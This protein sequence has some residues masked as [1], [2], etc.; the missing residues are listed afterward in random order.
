MKSLI[1]RFFKDR[2]VSL[3]VYCVA[4]IGFLEMYVAIYPSISSQAARFNELFASYPQEFL[5]AFGIDRLDMSTLENYIAMEHFSMIWPLMLVI[6][7]ISIAGGALAGEIDRG[8]IELLLARPISRLKLFI[9]R[10]LYGFIALVIFILATVFTVIPLAEMH[11]VTYDADRYL[12]ISILGLFF[13]L[14][15]FSLSMLV[16]ALFSE[17]GR[18]SMIMGGSLVL[19]YVLNVVAS[20]KENLSDLKY[21]SFFHYFDAQSALTKGE[22][23]WTSIW[24]FAGI[25]IVS[26]II[27]AMVWKRRDV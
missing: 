2:R 6:F 5:K 12:I 3:L 18:V 4:G 9:G 20:L 23:N 8:T 15:V 17:R 25:I 27:G 26:T 1:T 11:K 22:L 7:M 21:L 19:M 13:G 16:S 10:Y 24:V 14:A